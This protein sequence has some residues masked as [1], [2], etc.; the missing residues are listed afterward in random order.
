MDYVGAV[1]KKKKKKKKKQ[2]LKQKTKKKYTRQLNRLT[3]LGKLRFIHKECSTQTRSF[4]SHKNVRV[5][6][7]AR[8][9]KVFSGIVVDYLQACEKEGECCDLAPHIPEDSVDPKGHVIS[10]ILKTYPLTR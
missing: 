1:L 9:L 5:A 4:D 10:K 6:R 8:L 7:S 3:W 2:D